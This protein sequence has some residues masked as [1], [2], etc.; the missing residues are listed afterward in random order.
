MNQL[1]WTVITLAG[2]CPIML[3][4]NGV[5]RKEGNRKR[6]HLSRTP[7]SQ[8]HILSCWSVY[9][10]FWFFSLLEMIHPNWQLDNNWRTC[11]LASSYP[12]FFLS[13]HF[14]RDLFTCTY[15]VEIWTPA[16]LMS[17]Q[18]GSSYNIC[19]WFGPEAD[20]EFNAYEFLQRVRNKFSIVIEFVFKYL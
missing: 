19:Y 17:A 7:V 10:I 8:H 1:E 2:S 15:M 5:E 16:P 20:S 3:H 14:H 9:Y 18:G 13:V 4:V 11:K 12:N 6:D